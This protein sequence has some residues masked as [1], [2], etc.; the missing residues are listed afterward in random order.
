MERRKVVMLLGD[1]KSGYFSEKGLFLLHLDLG[2]IAIV[3][4]FVIALSSLPNQKEQ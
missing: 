2:H 1:G 4:W 3:P